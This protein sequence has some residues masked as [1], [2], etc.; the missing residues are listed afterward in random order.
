[1]IPA[2]IELTRRRGALEHVKAGR[3]RAAIAAC[4]N[5]WTSLPGN[6]YKQGTKALPDLFVTFNRAGGAITA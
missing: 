5:E 2:A 4:A 6:T 3:L 1:M